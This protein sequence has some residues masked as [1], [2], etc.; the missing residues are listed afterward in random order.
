MKNTHYFYSTFFILY[1]GMLFAQES[2]VKT[3]I[4]AFQDYAE[5]HPVE[6][7]YLHLD[8]PYYAAGETMYFRAHLTDM[9]LKPD[10]VASRIIYVELSDAKKNLVKRA[11]LYSEQQE[12]AGQIQLSDSLPSANYHLRAYTNWMRNAGEDYFYHRD[13]Y[14]G[15]ASDRKQAITT[16]QVF[17]YQVSFF[18]EGGRLLAGLTNKVAFK[19]LGNDGLGAE[20][21]GILSDSEGDELLR[22]NSLHLGMGSFDFTPEKG[23]TYKVSVQS[24]GITKEYTLP[25]ATEGITLSVRQDE[26]SVYLTIR[27]TY[28]EPESLYLIEQSRHTVFYAFEVVAK[29]QEQQVVVDKTEFPSGIAQFTL[30]KGDRPVSERLLFIDRKDN[31]N[32]VVMPDKEKYQAREKEMVRIRV[33]DSSGQPV[34]GSFSLSVTDDKTVKPSIDEQNIKGSLLLDS[35]LKGYIESPGWYFASNEPIRAKALDNLLCTQG[36]SRFVWDKM[37]TTTTSN[38][39]PVESDFF[40]SG[41]VTNATGK[42]VKNIA[43]QLISNENVPGVA[44]TDENGQSGFFGFNCPEGAEFIL[45]SPTIKDNQK[46]SLDKQDNRYAQTNIIPLYKINTDNTEAIRTSY[47]EQ[48]GLQSKIREKAQINNLPEVIINK[49]IAKA[50]DKKISE[51]RTIGIRSYHYGEEKLNKKT[52]ITRLIQTLPKPARGPQSLFSKAPP[53]WYI[54]DDGMKTDLSGFLTIYGSLYAD[55]FESIDVLCA[56]DAITLYGIE[57]SSGAYVLKTKKDIRENFG[58]NASPIQLY[59]P[60]GYCV[61]K[62]FYVPNYDNPEVRED[63]TPDLR[64]TI[65]WNPVIRTNKEGRAQINFFTADNAGSYSYV[66]EGTGDSNIVSFYFQHF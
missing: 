12:F 22:F 41:K 45:Q 6:K 49:F 8:K 23:E 54:V 61:R 9:D 32:V 17:D 20:I 51:Q 39:Y 28:N 21:S 50:E 14:I 38:I 30:F 1:T 34:E 57:F 35:D 16:S 52:T 53:T 65:Y 56:E 13:I 66:L 4:N 47:L 44:M 25:A 46:I 26:K 64:S 55:M 10:N 48:V 59:R 5:N 42:P 24:N 18:P 31:L 2:P 11:L 27:S 3:A 19:A 33:T 37:A 36:W 15:N 7:I 62:E 43:V 60:E 58:S 29:E 63:S 40:I